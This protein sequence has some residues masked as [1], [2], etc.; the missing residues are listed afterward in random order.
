MIFSYRFIESLLSNSRY[1]RKS[2]DFANTYN[3]VWKTSP[4]FWKYQKL[5]FH[6]RPNLP[7]DYWIL[8]G[9]PT[10]HTLII[11]VRR[12]SI[13]SNTYKHVLEVTAFSKVC[14]SGAT[15]EST[16]YWQ[17][18]FSITPTKHIFPTAWRNSTLSNTYKRNL[19]FHHTGCALI[20][21][22][23]TTLVFSTDP[24]N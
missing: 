12:C 22:L 11:C 8:D 18:Y 23:F 2:W 16:N 9:T 6:C 21:F 3:H 4:G 19:K 15:A 17:I 10:L 20:A 7:S 14:S 13:S 5:V 1:F 24:S